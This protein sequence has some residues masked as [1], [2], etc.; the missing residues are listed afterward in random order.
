[1]TSGAAHK[2]DLTVNVCFYDCLNLEFRSWRI[3]E[4]FEAKLVFFLTQKVL[5]IHC[6]V[7]Y[8]THLNLEGK[9][10]RW[11]YD[12]WMR[13]EKCLFVR[14]CVRVR[15]REREREVV[16]VG[17]TTVTR[18]GTVA[19][20]LIYSCDTYLHNTYHFSLSRFLSLSLSPCKRVA[21]FRIINLPLTVALHCWKETFASVSRS[22]TYCLF[23][24]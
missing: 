15:E 10:V 4:D 24:H 23:C 6:K 18:K 16:G 5:M 13:K 12:F 8:L 17:R 20:L 19:Y 9:N 11:Y 2:S 3:L 14:A 21:H 7:M 1:V 22:M